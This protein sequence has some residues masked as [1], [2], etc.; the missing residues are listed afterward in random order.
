MARAETVWVVL[1]AREHPVPFTV[2][3]ELI[4]WLQRQ[5]PEIL[6]F[7]QVWRCQDGR[8]GEEATVVEIAKL[9]A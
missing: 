9:L 2:K 3:H 7:A 8:W 4:T 5:P 6:V 1:G